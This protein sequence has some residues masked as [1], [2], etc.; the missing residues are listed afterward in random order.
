MEPIELNT[1]R[2]K[3]KWCIYFLLY[4]YIYFVVCITVNWRIFSCLSSYKAINRL[5]I[6]KMEPNHKLFKEETKKE[7]TFFMTTD[8]VCNEIKIYL[9]RMCFIMKTVLRFSIVF[10]S[11]IVSRSCFMDFTLSNVMCLKYNDI[12]LY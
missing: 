7:K 11:L 5:H 4:E 1:E 6:E 9:I 10:C 3:W 12:V 2:F 8:F